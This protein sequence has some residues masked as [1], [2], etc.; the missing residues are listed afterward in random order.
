M[1]RTG[2][3]SPKFVCIPPRPHT[4]SY[5][6]TAGCG[7]GAS[8][9]EN[10][11][12]SCSTTAGWVSAGYHWPN[13]RD[14]AR[15]DIQVR[16]AQRDA[17]R[18]A[19]GPH[20]GE[21]ARFPRRARGA[22]RPIRLRLDV[23]GIQHDRGLAR[24]VPRT[25]P[26]SRLL[27]RCESVRV[28]PRMLEGKKVTIVPCPA[29]NAAGT[30]EQTLRELNRRSR[31]RHHPGRRR[32]RRRHRSTRRSGSASRTI[33]HDRNRGYPGPTRRRAASRR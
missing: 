26:L 21:G 31:R 12:R 27:P 15:P 8:L 10:H 23:P 6:P 25:A 18:G 28:S 9:P 3:P 4:K 13:R 20:G 2:R 24:G 19:E 16:G 29:Y 5:Q 32:Q 30:L 7:I 33:V 22:T 17:D 1:P 14:E 11:A